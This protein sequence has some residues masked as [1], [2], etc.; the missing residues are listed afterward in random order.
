MAGLVPPSGRPRLR[1]R[2]CG[3]CPRSGARHQRSIRTVS[4]Q[5]AQS[6]ATEEAKPALRHPAFSISTCAAKPLSHR[7]K[8]KRTW[9]QRPTFR[10]K[11]ALID[12]LAK[13]ERSAPP[14]SKKERASDVARDSL[15]QRSEQDEVRKQAEAPVAAL[16]K[17]AEE[18]TSSADQKLAASSAPPATASAPAPMQAP[19]GGESLPVPSHR[20]SALVPCS[21][22][23]SQAEPIRARW[24]KEQ[25]Q[26]MKPLAESAPQANRLETKTGRAFTTGQSSGHSRPTQ[27]ART[28]LQLCRSWN[29]WAG[30]RSG[31]GDGVEE[32]TSRYFSPWKPIRTP[33]CKSGRRLA[34]QRRN[35]YGLRKKP[36]RSL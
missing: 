33:I 22:K 6:V 32:Y 8:P 28:P 20:Q 14:P 9:L 25:E 24:L 18:V 31:R 30:A 13:R 16:S 17:S 34:P 26:A 2:P 15:K 5:A 23:E 11:T 19:A 12:K 27:A 36:V 10:R 29:R 1:R 3:S 7:R 35:C 21:M 4:R